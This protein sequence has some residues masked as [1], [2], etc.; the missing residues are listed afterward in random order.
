MLNSIALLEVGE[1]ERSHPPTTFEKNLL[2]VFSSLEDIA[3]QFC[4]ANCCLH[5]SAEKVSQPTE[6]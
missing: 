1:T 4:L 2:M 6:A 3:L 5:Y